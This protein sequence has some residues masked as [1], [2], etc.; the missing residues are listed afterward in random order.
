MPS[1]KER[2]SGVSDIIKCS[3]S[4]YTKP[5]KYTSQ[6]NH[7][8]ESTDSE[9][10]HQREQEQTGKYTHLKKND[11]TDKK[12]TWHF[13]IFFILLIAQKTQADSCYLF[14][15]LSK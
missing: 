14:L 12:D 6:E 3:C 9:N 2:G 11:N 8:N 10:H 5:H 1:L 4:Q 15:L 13:Q 7:K